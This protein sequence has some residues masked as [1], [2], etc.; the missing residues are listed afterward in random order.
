MIKRCKLF[1]TNNVFIVVKIYDTIGWGT[2]AIL[3]I[4]ILSWNAVTL[5]PLERHNREIQRP[6]SQ[7]A[8]F[9]SI[10]FLWKNITANYVL[11]LT[12]LLAIFVFI[13]EEWIVNNAFTYIFLVVPFGFIDVILLYQ[14]T[15]VAGALWKLK[16][17][18]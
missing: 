3:Q 9:A 7:P 1:V 14:A 8:W 15:E 11:Y 13:I 18:V 16:V 6:P 17:A 5:L 4:K 2:L 10:F 12:D